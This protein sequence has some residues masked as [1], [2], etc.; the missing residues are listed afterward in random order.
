VST[1]NPTVVINDIAGVTIK[2]SDETVEIYFL[3]SLNWEEWNEVVGYI[4]QMISKGSS[5]IVFNLLKL[6]NFTSFDI[7]VWVTL[8]AKIKSLSG[9]LDFF[10]GHDSNVHKYMKFA[11]LDELF[12]IIIKNTDQ[13][14]SEINVLD[15]VSIT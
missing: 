13:D 11:K 4:D 12:S 14:S 3:K 8:N 2:R 15:D 1:K 9:E 10:L 6:T 5:H 7:G